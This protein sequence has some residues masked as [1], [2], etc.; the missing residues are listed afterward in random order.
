MN[1]AFGFSSL[2]WCGDKAA[3]EKSRMAGY[4]FHA[5]GREMSAE[6]RRMYDLPISL[7]V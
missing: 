7:E 2:V 5:D 3:L 6:N 4:V 1:I